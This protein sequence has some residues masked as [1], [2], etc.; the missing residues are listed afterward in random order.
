MLGSIFQNSQVPPNWW[1]YR[2]PPK[3]LANNS[4]LSQTPDAAGKAPMPSAPPVL[5]MTQV[6]QYSMTT[7]VQPVAGNF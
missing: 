2:M 5:S 6:P 1:G 4:G 3:F 7:T